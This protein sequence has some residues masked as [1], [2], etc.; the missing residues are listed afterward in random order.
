M[1]W[2]RA[3][4]SFTVEK[5]IPRINTNVREQKSLKAPVWS[6][7]INTPVLINS[8]IPLKSE[9]KHSCKLCKEPIVRN[10]SEKLC[11]YA[12]R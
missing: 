8:M 3:Q 12:G 7:K 4:L 11:I 5:D 2:L 10:I 6:V 9:L 1:Y